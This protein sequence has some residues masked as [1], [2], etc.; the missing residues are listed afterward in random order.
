MDS[1]VRF[2][3]QALIE[4]RKG[5]G[6][7]AP[8]PAVGAVIVDDGRVVGRGFH[9]RAGMPHA[10]I[11]AL[12]DAGEASRGAT[13]YVTLEPCSHHGKT[14][15]CADA[16]IAAGVSRVVVG[17]LDPNPLVA[18][19]GIRKLEAAGIT[20]TVGVE[21]EACRDLIRWYTH[22]METGRPYVI[23]KAAQTLDGRIAT[24]S[25]DSKWISSEDSRRF[26]HELRD[27]V[28]GILVGSKTVL[29]DDPR[30][31]CRIENGRDPLRIVVDRNLEIS[32]AAGV[33][34]EK[35]IIFTARD[36]QSRPDL[37][38]TETAMVRLDLDSAGHLSWD[39][40]LAELGRRGLHSLV[41]EGGSGIISDL[42]QKGRADELL[43]FVAAKLLGGGKGLVE[44]GSP[45]KI[46]DSMRFIIRD[47]ALIGGDIKIEMVPEG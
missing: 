25:G 18:G 7:T 22:W 9:P 29:A 28:D 44:W 33:L 3:Q 19:N 5:L 8:N 27:R 42:L 43:I 24:A 10:E 21:E 32:A 47:V 39:A 13:I 15:P 35:C 12:K 40:M 45:E 36:P 14:P 23:I 31:T 17:T 37:L 34:G 2:M 20:V 4:A 38:A 16:L 30:L 11:Y 46:A 26:V 41:V 1:D 6:R